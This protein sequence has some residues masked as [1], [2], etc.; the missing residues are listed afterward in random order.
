M[1]DL[2]EDK[3]LMAALQA[4]VAALVSHTFTPLEVEGEGQ[5]QR[6]KCPWCFT[7]VPPDDASAL[8]AHTAR[9]EPTE[10]WYVP[11]THLNQVRVDDESTYLSD[12]VFLYFIHSACGNPVGL[13]DDWDREWM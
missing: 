3:A 10:A 13:P 8:V 7:E 11:A 12:A 6:L 5:E 2:A 1:S 4:A 9:V